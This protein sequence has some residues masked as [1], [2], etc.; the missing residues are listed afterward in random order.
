MIGWLVFSLITGSL[1]LAGHKE[2]NETDKNSPQPAQNTPKSRNVWVKG[3]YGLAFKT[4]PDG[5][6]YEE[7]AKT[8]EI[9]T[10]KQYEE[11]EKRK[12]AERIANRTPEEK[13]W[14]EGIEKMRADIRRRFEAKQE[15][16]KK[17]PEYREPSPEF[18]DRRS[19]DR[20][21][22]RGLEHR[23]SE[24]PTKRDLL[25]NVGGFNE[26]NDRITAYWG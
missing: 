7:Y 13:E 21:I 25:V 17:A 10:P 12:D 20:L 18:Y 11:D 2:L 19:I 24:T 26:Q 4:I 1:V 9:T 8:H 22:D 14:W 15:A 5:V 6:S 3:L 23:S 16:M